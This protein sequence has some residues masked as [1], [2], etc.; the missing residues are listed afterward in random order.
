MPVCQG[1]VLPNLSMT[2]VRI[3]PV[4]NCGAITT[5][6]ES[7]PDFQTFVTR[8]VDGIQGY[9]FVGLY[10]Y[11]YMKHTFELLSPKFCDARWI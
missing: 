4:F 10:Q 8:G 5:F 6:L 7:V 2:L 1:G 9:I 3:P 11:K